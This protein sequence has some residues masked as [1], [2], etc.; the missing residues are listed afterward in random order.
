[1]YASENGMQSIVETLIAKG[2]DLNFKD[3]AEK[4]GRTIDVSMYVCSH[5]FH[6]HYG[7]KLKLV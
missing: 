1:M 2:A 6:V 3:F 5:F 7:A 4:T